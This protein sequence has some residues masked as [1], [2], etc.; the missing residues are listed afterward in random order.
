MLRKKCGDHMGEEGK[1]NGVPRFRTALYA[2][3]VMLFLC[4]GSVL[5]LILEM[6]IYKE[7]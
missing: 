3:D 5:E 2:F 4:R 6:E 7:A 1:G